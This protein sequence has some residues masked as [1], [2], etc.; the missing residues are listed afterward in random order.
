M[1]IFH[2]KASSWILFILTFLTV[3]FTGIYLIFLPTH[4]EGNQSIIVLLFFTV[5]GLALLAA[6]YVS[7]AETKWTLTDSEIKLEWIGQ[8]IFQNKPSL[9]INWSDIEEYKFQPD[10]NFDLLSLRL[11][12]GREIR[13][14][15]STFLTK[16]DFEKFIRYFEKEVG[17]CNST[18]SLGPSNIK[19]SKNIYETKAGMWFA[20]FAAF[21]MI[22]IPILSLFPHKGKINWA[23]LGIGYSGGIYYIL[24][25][26][27][28]R[29]K[30]NDIIE[31]KS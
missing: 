15:H 24:Q 14:W 19:R 22:A 20:I 31:P 8:F 29:K 2:I 5:F 26:L 3:L 23:G 28:H 12:D 30:M 1:H 18:N 11:K 27:S 7:Q 17:K 21:W 6:K 9:K 16:D 10:R 25:V 13:L 4:Q